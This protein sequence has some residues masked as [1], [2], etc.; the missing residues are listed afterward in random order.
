MPTMTARAP[1]LTDLLADLE[2]EHPHLDDVIA[3]RPAADW[4]LPT[5]AEGW[6]VRDTVS[7]LAFFDE[8]ARDASSRPGEFRAGLA[9]VWADPQAFNDAAANRGRELPAGEVLE[10]W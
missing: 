6:S 10:W 8:Q 4:D 3:V 5:P 1:A 9:E 2:A 7:H